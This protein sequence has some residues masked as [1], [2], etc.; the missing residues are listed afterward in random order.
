MIAKRADEWDKLFHR[1][2]GWTGADGIYSIPI[3]GNETINGSSSEKTLFVFSDTFISRV[4]NNDRRLDWTIVNN[5][6]ALLD[7]NMPLEEK[8]QFFWNQDSENQPLTLFV[9]ETPQSQPGD[10]TG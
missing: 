5:T 2:N 10:C 3:S 6:H 9:P 7:G 4:T 8:T 1:K